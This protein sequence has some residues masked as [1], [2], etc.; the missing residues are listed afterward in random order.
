MKIAVTTASGQLGRTI[1]QELIKQIGKENVVGIAR[2]PAKAES[3]GIEVRKGDYNSYDDFNKALKGID[4]VLVVSG[5]DAPEKRVGQHRNIISAAENNAVQKLVYTSIIG[6]EVQTEFDPI[7][8]SNRQTES[9]IANS[10]LGWAIGR[11]G[12]YLEPDLEY[13]ENYK[14]AGCIWN[15]AGDGK[16]GYTSRQELAEAYAQMLMNDDLNGAVYNLT[17]IPITQNELAE[18]INK[19]YGT[20]LFYKYLSDEEYLAERKKELGDFFGT[21]VAGIYGG[22]RK[23]SFD[24]SS[25]FQ[26]VVG[27]PPKTVLQLIEESKA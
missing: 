27:R 1:A 17:T 5:L 4:K 2:T 9:D 21:V 14:K 26:K 15:N 19:V 3:L 12:L 22:I 8:K 18:Y 25:D 23:G 24:V 13:I 6:S 11:N 7:I 10:K 16:C 20:N